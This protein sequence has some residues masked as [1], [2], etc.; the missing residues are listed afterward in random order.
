MTQ[1]THGG[2]RPGAGR[3]STGKKTEYLRT[4]VAKPWTKEHQAAMEWW[5]S[6]TPRD[7]LMYIIEL[8]FD[9]G[10]PEPRERNSPP[11]EEERARQRLIKLCK[12]IAANFEEEEEE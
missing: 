5:E 7:R 1:N 3:P 2:K 8:W 4:P 9:C 6:K 10:C 12:E 11:L